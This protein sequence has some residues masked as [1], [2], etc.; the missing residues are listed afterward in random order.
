MAVLTLKNVSVRYGEKNVL[1]KID[2]ELSG[3]EITAV[4][5]PSGCG[6]STLLHCMNG[7]IREVHGAHMTGDLYLRGQN[8]QTL[9]EEEIRRRIG[10]VSQMPTPF[11]F[12]VYK[13]ITYAPIYY[14][15]KDKRKLEKIVKDA[16]QMCGLY[17]EV[18]GDLSHPANRLSG[19]QQ[20][21]LCI[22]RALAV[23]PEILLLD[24]PCS[25]LDAVNTERI[26]QLLLSLK[27]KYTIVLVTHNL[28]Q[29]KRLADHVIYMDRHT[30]AARGDAGTMFGGGLP[31]ETRRA[32]ER[33]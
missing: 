32:M 31:E 7:M 27:K 13:N 29:A 8:F 16:L 1:E 33:L 9:Q 11:P 12:S 2:L 10:L 23:N 15:V 17:E 5:G 19:G 6:K 22:A 4:I 30:I 14:G 28:A 18:K 20:Q 24:E 25:A 26:E 3:G 21:R